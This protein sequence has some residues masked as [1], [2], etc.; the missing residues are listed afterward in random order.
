LAV[1]AMI[2]GL[3]LVVCGGRHLPIRL[4]HALPVILLTSGLI[5][6]AACY[7]LACSIFLAGRPTTPGQIAAFAEL[8]PSELWQGACGSIDARMRNVPRPI[9]FSSVVFAIS[10]ARLK[11]RAANLILDENEVRRRQAHA[12]RSIAGR[13]RC[14]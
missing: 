1:A 7:P 8:T 6:F 4:E 13:D 12:F 9:S 14:I 11:L 3:G 2:T 5:G 10:A